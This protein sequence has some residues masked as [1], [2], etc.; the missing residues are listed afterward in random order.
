MRAP[1]EIDFW[2]GFALVTIFIDHVPGIFFENYTMRNFGICDAAELFV[3][4]AGCSMRLLIDGRRGRLP[5]LESTIRLES[6]AITIYTVQLI[7]TQLALAITAAGALYFANPQFLEWNNAEAAFQDPVETQLGLALLTHQ[8]FY[9]DILPLYVVLMAMAPL[10]VTADR[11]SRWLPLPLSLA[12]YFAIHKSGI[13]IPTWPVEG[14]WYFNPFTWQLVFV[15]GFVLADP[16]GPLAVLRKYRLPLRVIGFFIVAA[17]LWV[18][19]KEWTPDPLAMPEP[20]LLFTFDKTF[21]APARILHLLALVA[22]IGG[23]FV[24]IDR[25]IPW[26][27]G[28]LSML[29]RNS[30]WV[31]SLGSITALLSQYVR[32]MLGGSL[33]VDSAVLA[34]G[35]I[36]M[37]FTA[38]TVEWRVRTRKS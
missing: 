34:V 31:F 24:Y 2:R 21:A 10:F 16:V 11:I 5:V 1:N 8:L 3:F 27:T 15:L 30:L 6:R 35:I 23:T 38:W 29:G 17:G 22:L 28:F 33:W 13:N 19:L 25:A 37:G 12:L 32:Y 20:R 36:S 4:L 9:F 14:R 26:V 7:L 18:A